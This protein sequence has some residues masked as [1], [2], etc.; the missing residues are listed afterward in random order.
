[1][2]I[3]IWN[4]EFRAKIGPNSANSQS[5]AEASTIRTEIHMMAPKPH[6]KATRNCGILFRSLPAGQTRATRWLHDIVLRVQCVRT[7]PRRRHVVSQCCKT[8]I[9][10]LQNIFNVCVRAEWAICILETLTFLN[11]LNF[12]P[13]FYSIIYY[14]K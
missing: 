12:W 3:Q 4:F 1:M 2:A 7:R 10:N 11:G 13:L 9:L 5:L 6:M 8:I 14:N